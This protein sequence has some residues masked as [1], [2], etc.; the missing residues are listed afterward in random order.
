[1]MPEVSSIGKTAAH[2]LYNAQSVSVHLPS[3]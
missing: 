1:M 2:I 3:L